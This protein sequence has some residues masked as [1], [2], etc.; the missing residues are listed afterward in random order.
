VPIHTSAYPSYFL[1]VL[2]DDFRLL[3][4]KDRVGEELGLSQNP[5]MSLSLNCASSQSAGDRVIGFH[6]VSGNS[7]DRVNMAPQLQ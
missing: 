5:S 3:L 6:M 2:F 1:R 4:F 7:T